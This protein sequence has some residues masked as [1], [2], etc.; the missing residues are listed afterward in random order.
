LGAKKPGSAAGVD[1]IQSG[2]KLEFQPLVSGLNKACALFDASETA[3]D[4]IH[5]AFYR[6]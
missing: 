6:F 3:L 5:A 4:R 1:A 2:S